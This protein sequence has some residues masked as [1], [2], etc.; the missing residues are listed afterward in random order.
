MKKEW[1]CTIYM[2]VFG[3]VEIAIG[4]LSSIQSVFKRYSDHRYSGFT[5]INNPLHPLHPCSKD[6]ATTDISDSHI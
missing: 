1:V 3:R 4:S 6:K 5:H 2:A